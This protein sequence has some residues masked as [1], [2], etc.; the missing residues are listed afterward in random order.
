MPGMLTAAALLLA[1]SVNARAHTPYDMFPESEEVFQQLEAD[2]RRIQLGAAY[3]RL[4][5]QDRADLALG[6]SWG[7]TRWRTNDDYW[8]WQWNLEAMAYSRFTI[9]GSLNAF[10]TVDFVANL[11]VAVKHGPFSARAMLFHESSHLGDDYIRRTNDQGFRYS[12]DG[13]RATFSAEPLTWARVYCGMTYL[14]HTIPDPARK[15]AQAGVE[16][17]SR[18]VGGSKRYPLRLFA[19]SDLQ[20]KEA[21]DYRANSRSMAG[22]IVGYDGVPRSMRAF[23][24]RFEGYSP[25]G[26]L[27]RRRE[28]FTDIGVSFHF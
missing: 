20:F 11:P 17:T 22:V 25:F 9:G 1:F 7:M 19:S 2:P 18:P 8:V 16:L 5:G 13:V 14:L 23:V 15:A 10:E 21:T 6:H 3:Y 27:Y 4:D 28:R 12:V 24:G 26:Q